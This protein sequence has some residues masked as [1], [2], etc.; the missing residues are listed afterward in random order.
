MHTPSNRRKTL[1]GT[2]D[3]LCPEMINYRQHDNRVDIWTIGVLAY[4]LV[5]GRPPFE[6]QNEMETKR[7]I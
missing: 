4:E 1:C 6:S 7:K 2:L 3:Y 5:T